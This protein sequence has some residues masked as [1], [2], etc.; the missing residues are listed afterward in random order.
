MKKIIIA[1]VMIVG[2]M[3]VLGSCFNDS[4]VAGETTAHLEPEQE[5]ETL[6]EEEQIKKNVLDLATKMKELKDP[7][8][9]F[10]YF[11]GDYEISGL[12]TS[13]TNETFNFSR[14]DSVLYAV[15]N[16]NKY[17]GVDA[18]GYIF[19]AADYG[20]SSEVIATL[21][22]EAEDASKSTI[23]TAFGIDTGSV[24]DSSDSD[25]E[26]PEI[27]EDML[28][29]SEDKK[30][31]EI[32]KSYTDELMRFFCET[33]ELDEKQIDGFMKNYNGSA[34]YYV[35]KN[36]I[37]VDITFGNSDLGNFHVKMSYS[38]DEYD[39]TLGTYMLFEYSNPA[40][41]ITTPFVNELTYS[42]VVYKGVEPISATIKVKTVTDESYYDGNYYGAPY[43][44]A[45]E[46]VTTTFKLDCS[47]GA[48]PKCTANK[49]SVWKENY[50]GQMLNVKYTWTM[51]V[52]LGKQSSQLTYAWKENGEIVYS[53]RASKVTFATPV[54]FPQVPARVT[55]A[56]L[57]EVQN[58]FS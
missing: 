26:D 54:S 50:Q 21:F 12:T 40:A 36:E 34:V 23:F 57:D 18:D 30:T 17:Y 5:A 49:E 4:E 51:A 16:N 2:L 29:V 14:K 39:Q 20:S 35:D 44:E 11:D 19:Y 58:M 27:T 25:E 28:T 53:L 10:S 3:L 15:G 48:R 22:S 37:V 47:D 24:Y 45:E 9:L 46:T 33:L 31:C 52:D 1:L 38:F 8:E 56:I 55:N 43:I 42:D 41:G 7:A 6:S 13:Y 32:S